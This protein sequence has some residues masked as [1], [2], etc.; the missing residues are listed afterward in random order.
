VTSGPGQVEARA[1]RVVALPVLNGPRIAGLPSDEAGFLR[2]DDR[3]RVAGAEDIWG[4]GDG[5]TSPIKQGG[6]AAQT[7]NAVARQVAARAG[8]DV[9]TEGFRYPVLRAEL[10]TGAQSKF[11][12]G[13]VGA[14]DEQA[15]SAADHALWWPPTK[16]AAPHLTPYLASIDAGEAPPGSPRARVVHA[17]GDPSGGIEVLG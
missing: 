9:T 10:F 16:V 3:G 2:V 7:A 17:K 8:A 11:L 14:S 1:Q 13:L 4:A 15:S 12:R 5:T 6:I